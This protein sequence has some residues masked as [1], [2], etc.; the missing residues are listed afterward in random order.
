MLTSYVGSFPLSYSE[1]NV[2]RIVHD[3]I[4]IPIDCPNYPQLRDFIHQFLE[5]FINAGILSLSN[6]RYLLREELSLRIDYESALQEAKITLDILRKDEDLRQRIQKIKAYVTGPFTLA[7][8]I[9]LKLEGSMRST[10]LSELDMIEKLADYVYILAYNMVDLGY[11]YVVVDEPMLSVIVGTKRIMFDYTTDDIIDVLNR[12]A[13][14]I[15]IDM[16]IHVCGKISGL[17]SETLAQTEFKIL[18]HE[19]AATPS[20]FRTITRR[21]LEDNDKFISIGVISSSDPH[22][23]GIE[24][25]RRLILKGVEQYGIE[26]IAFVKPDCGFRGLKGKLDE[27]EAYKVSLEKLRILRRARDIVAKELRIEI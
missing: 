15:N 20:N 8:Q 7:S 3:V 24:G 6:K 18:D 21:V 9:Y 5:P 13:K 10:A 25:V 14:R 12:I 17:L 1:D 19:F 22:I 2:V 4:K 16:G 27:E 11:E 26:H 23:E